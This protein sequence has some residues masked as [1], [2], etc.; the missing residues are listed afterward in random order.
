MLMGQSKEAAAKK[1]NLGAGRSSRG[2]MNW[3]Q[4][5]VM[6]ILA[7]GAPCGKAF[8]AFDCNNASA[9][10]MQYSLLDPEPC[11]NMQKSHAMERDLQGEIVQIKK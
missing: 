7:A 4:A 8:Q 10:V 11:S 2:Q 6:M 3:L 1:K 9:Q 5:A